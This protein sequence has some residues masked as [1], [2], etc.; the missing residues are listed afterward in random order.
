MGIDK[1]VVQAECLLQIAE[2]V[3][4][5]ADVIALAQDAGDLSGAKARRGKEDG[6]PLDP[7]GGDA[8]DV[9]Y[10]VSRLLDRA[11]IPE[12][13]VQRPLNAVLVEAEQD[14]DTR[15]LDVGIDD[16]D[17]LAGKSREHGEIG[18]QIRLAGTAAKGMDRND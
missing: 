5:S 3:V 14:V 17:T 12:V 2:T 9:A 1:K 8:Q 13:V 4:E 10:V 11:A 16:S 15:R 18:G 6:R 7:C